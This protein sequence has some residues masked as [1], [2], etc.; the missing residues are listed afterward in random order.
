[1]PRKVSIDDAKML[2]LRIQER[3]MV[4]WNENQDKLSKTLDMNVLLQ[5][6]ECYAEDETYLSHNEIEIE[7]IERIIASEFA[8]ELKNTPL[9]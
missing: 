4:L 5:I 6:L 3:V 1:M 9:P 7:Q 2:K 8:Q